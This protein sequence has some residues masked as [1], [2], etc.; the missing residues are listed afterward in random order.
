MSH[1]LFRGLCAHFFNI[2]QEFMND[3]EEVAMLHVA[4]DDTRV[5]LTN[6]HAKV[7]STSVTD[8]HASIAIQSSCMVGV[9][10]IQSPSKVTT[11]RWLKS[12]KLGADLDKSIE[13][14]FNPGIYLY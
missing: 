4:L 10:D 8:T 5:K 12:K 1:N 3:D 7:W 9:E 13:E 6:Y 14:E 2:A 11:K